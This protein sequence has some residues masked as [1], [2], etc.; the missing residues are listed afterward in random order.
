MFA[1]PLRCCSFASMGA[2]RYRL[3]FSDLRDNVEAAAIERY[4]I[5]HESPWMLEAEMSCVQVTSTVVIL[6]VKITIH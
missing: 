2:P 3:W 6:L 4:T 5:R 1:D